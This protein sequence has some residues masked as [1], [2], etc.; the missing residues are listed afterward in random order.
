MFY[1]SQ[2]CSNMT[3]SHPFDFRLLMKRC[4]SYLKP[5]RHDHGWYFSLKGTGNSHLDLAYRDCWKIRPIP[6]TPALIS[7]MMF[8]KNHLKF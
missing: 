6:N 5:P 8:S 2:P 1:Y 3:R 4:M 7:S